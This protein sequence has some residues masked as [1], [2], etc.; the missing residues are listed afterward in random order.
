MNELTKICP[1][2]GKEFKKSYNCSMYEWNNTR[3]YCSRDCLNKSKK[4]K[5]SWN[6][7]ISC[8]EETKKKISSS[9]KG[10]KI[11]IKTPRYT[12]E[13]KNKISETLKEKYKNGELKINIPK[14]KIGEAN[15]N[16]KGG[17]TTENE[18]ARKSIEYKLWRKSCFERD[19]WTC[20]ICGQ[21]G[22]KLVVHHINNFAEFPELRLAIDNG[23]T[24]CNDCHKEFHKT[25]GFKNNT[26]EQLKQLQYNDR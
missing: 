16:W 6:K 3:K 21:N 1:I 11:K 20:Q 22:G 15:P 18:K 14:P 26:R 8:S 25:Y 4:G 5:T 12:E 17:V 13:Q 24:L 10:K 2:C 7:G 9:K 23:I 19:N